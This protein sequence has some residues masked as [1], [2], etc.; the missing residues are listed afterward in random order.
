[1]FHSVSLLSQAPL[2]R[3][4]RALPS[5]LLITAYL[6]LRPSCLG[7]ISTPRMISLVSSHTLPSAA[8]MNGQWASSGSSGS[9]GYGLLDSDA[10]FASR[11]LS[12][13]LQINIPDSTINRITSE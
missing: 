6:L 13:F 7:T 8:A 4:S 5:V 2:V 1:M 10:T 12:S 11:D 3:G 9:G